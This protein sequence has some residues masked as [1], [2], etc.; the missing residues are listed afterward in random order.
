MILNLYGLFE[1]QYH[2]KTICNGIKCKHNDCNNENCNHNDCRGHKCTYISDTRTP[3]TSVQVHLT[4]S[5]TIYKERNLVQ[6]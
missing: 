5:Y 4:K 3:F 2:Y 1:G 6:I